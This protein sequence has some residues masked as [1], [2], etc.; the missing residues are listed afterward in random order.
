MC[1]SVSASATSRPARAWKCRAASSSARDRRPRQTAGVGLR[2]L[3]R[4]NAHRPGRCGR[5]VHH[6]ADRR[7]RPPPDRRGNQN[8]VRQ[9]ADR[10]QPHAQRRPRRQLPRL[11]RGPRLHRKDGQGD[12]RGRR[13]GLELAARR[14]GRRR[15]RL[16]AEPL[17]QPPVPDAR[18]PGD[19]PPRQARHAAPRR[20]RPPRRPH[21]PRRGR[22]GLPEPGGQEQDSRRRRPFRLPQHRRR[23]RPGFARLRRL[24][25][26]HV[27]P[28]TE[29][30]R[31][32]SSC[33][34]RAATSP[35][36]TICR[37]L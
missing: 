3:R 30:R 4:R 25:P 10:R 18:R 29:R 21:R 23:R 36:S 15:L 16:G 31:R 34:A 2:R 22:A 13:P 6:R 32:S 5:P 20:N 19:H 37:K 17:I 26:K 24:P 7:E 12:R 27:R 11:R 8:L 1:K 28:I 14:R 33:S 35:R 9:R